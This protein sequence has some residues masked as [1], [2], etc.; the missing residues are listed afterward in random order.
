MP[1]RST[2]LS[3][4]G[5]VPILI[6]TITAATSVLRVAGST[7]VLEG[8]EVVFNTDRC[9]DKPFVRTGWRAMHINL[10][11][12]VHTE[13]S[14]QEVAL[15]GIIVVP[16]L[17]VETIQVANELLDRFITSLPCVFMLLESS[18]VAIRRV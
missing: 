12:Y 4:R 18:N 10:L 7:G 8:P 11:L 14:Q 1:W 15:N 5:V 9:R 3:L 2:S 16:Q 17:V 6:A 13:L